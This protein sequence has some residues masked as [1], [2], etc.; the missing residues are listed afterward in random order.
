MDILS[1]V[2]H[3]DDSHLSVQPVPIRQYHTSTLIRKRSWFIL[4]IVAT[5]LWLPTNAFAA[6]TLDQAIKS[7]LD[8]DCEGLTGEGGGPLKLAEKPKVIP[9]G[10]KSLSEL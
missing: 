10:M 3:I 4:A 5:I 8:N 7:L 6:Q 1:N 9:M 2:V